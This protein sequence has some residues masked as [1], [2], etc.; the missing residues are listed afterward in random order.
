MLSLFFEFSDRINRRKFWLG[1]IGVLIYFVCFG[2]LVQ[3][4]Q[5]IFGKGISGFQSIFLLALI[6]PPFWAMFA[7]SIKRLHDTNRT[8]WWSL[9]LIVG[10]PFFWY[11]CGLAG[12]LGDNDYG[13]GPGFDI[14]NEIEAMANSVKPNQPSFQRAAS[15]HQ[16]ATG[17]LL[18]ISAKL[19]NQC[20]AVVKTL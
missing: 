20:L 7:L 8:G 10:T 3:A 9:L 2:F 18:Q 19:Q 14:S 11:L 13:A 15:R 4:I 5:G 17:N 16:F 12:D 6:I 1:M